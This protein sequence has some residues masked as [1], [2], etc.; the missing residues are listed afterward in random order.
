MK[1]KD[2]FLSMSM[3][4]R[5]SFAE[6]CGTSYGH[7]KNVAYGKTCDQF[8]AIAIERETGGAVTVAELRPAFAEALRQAGYVKLDPEHKAAA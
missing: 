6:R 1:L 7:M 5:I 4:D 8:L 2:Y 3:N